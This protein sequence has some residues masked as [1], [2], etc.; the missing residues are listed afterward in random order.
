[1]RGGGECVCLCALFYDANVLEVYI[2]VAIAASDDAATRRGSAEASL[3]RFVVGNALR[4]G[5]TNDANQLF[6]HHH[7]AFL[8]Y[9]VVFDYAEADVG[10]YYRELI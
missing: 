9:L 5:T 10:S 7:H 3:H 8:Y 6:R 1:M 2:L 4:I